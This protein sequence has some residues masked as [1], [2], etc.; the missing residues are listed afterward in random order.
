MWG[1][2]AA[3]HGMTG[4]AEAGFTAAVELLPL[5][6]WR[7]LRQHTRE[8]VLSGRAGLAADAAAWAISNGHLERAVELLELGRNVLWSQLL[9]LR[10]DLDDLRHDHPDVARRLDAVREILDQPAAWPDYQVPPVAD[11]AATG[12]P[13]PRPT[14]EARR[15]DE[16]RIGAA[17][18]WDRLMTE[19]RALPGYESF[20]R[21]PEYGDLISD[22]GDRT[23]V[24]IN[25]SQY[26]CDA[27]AVSGS[28]IRLIPLPGL[29]PGAVARQA[30]RFREA[31]GQL[32]RSGAAA[33]DGRAPTGSS[34]PAPK[35]GDLICEVLAWLG[36]DVAFPVLD[37][38]GHGSGAAAGP[39]PGPRVWWC[40]TGPLAALPLHAAGV[41]ERG[42]R[43]RAVHDRVVSSYIPSLR[44]LHHA[45]GRVRAEAAGTTM[46]EGQP[47]VLLVT[48][49]TTSYLPGGAP[50]PYVAEEA[51]VVTRHF[52]LGRAVTHY[53]ETAATRQA[54][55]HALATHDYAHF[56]CHGG[57]DPAEPSAAGLYMGDGP[58]TIAALSERDLPAGAA[59]FAFLSACHTSAPSPDLP[60]ETITMAAALQL[61]GFR[62]VIATLWAIADKQA[63]AVADEVYQVLA[64]RQEPA[65]DVPAAHALHAAITRLRDKGTHPVTWSAY[66]HT[67]P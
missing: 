3:E 8:E 39:R 2:S 24:I 50:L 54:V 40:P 11:E 16:A 46:G 65:G 33:D 15:Q 29:T 51:G 5:Q 63:P 34:Q 25:I 38:L 4:E 6:A 55:L 18:D 32:G 48:M 13:S 43:G 27:L 19:V 21:G 59:R 31:L 10:G 45:G 44:A 26:R 30:A 28:G 1:Q 37:A 7:G 23:V 17:H 47:A 20:L 9:Q 22:I 62:H 56:A 52:P 14:A 67:G 64:A 35:P 60:D 12:F 36:D 61:A 66:V 58:L 49:P 53:N 41:H 42:Q 57:I